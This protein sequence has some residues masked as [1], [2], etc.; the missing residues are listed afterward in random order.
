MVP[1]AMSNDGWVKLA[2]GGTPVGDADPSTRPG[3]FGYAMLEAVL[4]RAAHDQK[5]AR[6]KV[7]ALGMAT[8]PGTDTQG[9]WAAKRDQSN[10]LMNG[11]GSEPVAVP[12]H[13][14]ATAPVE[15]GPA[16]H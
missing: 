16:G 11:S 12:G 5:V 9:S 13:A 14:V 2:A 1:T 15:I 8:T 7:P 6:S 10:C 4:G 3:G